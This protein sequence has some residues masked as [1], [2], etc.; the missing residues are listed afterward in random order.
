[1][2]VIKKD[3]WSEPFNRSKYELSIAKALLHAGEDVKSEVM[4][5]F[6]G[7]MTAAL[8]KEYESASVVS[9]FDIEVF[10][11]SLLS[12]EYRKYYNA[13]I[14]EIKVKKEEGVSFEEEIY[15]RA[16]R[17]FHRGEIRL[18]QDTPTQLFN[19]EDKKAVNAIKRATT[20]EMK[21][22]IRVTDA[23]RQIDSLIELIEVL[24]G[25]DYYFFV[26][27]NKASSID[28]METLGYERERIYF[29][30]SSTLLSLA[31]QN[32]TLYKL[33]TTHT[34]SVNVNARDY[35]K[36]IIGNHRVKVLFSDNIYDSFCASSERFL[37]NA[38][39]PYTGMIYNENSS[40]ER[41][42][43]N[44]MKMYDKELGVFQYSKFT[45]AVKT[46]V[47]ALNN[48][49]R[50]REFIMSERK[51]SISICGFNELMKVMNIEIGSEKSIAI[52]N[53]LSG[54]MAEAAYLASAKYAEN[55][56]RCAVYNDE[57]IKNIRNKSIFRTEVVDA[58]TNNG[59]Y[60]SIVIGSPAYG[61]LV[62]DTVW[63]DAR[64]QLAYMA[65]Y[66]EFADTPIMGT[67]QFADKIDRMY[68]NVMEAWR[69]GLGVISLKQHLEKEDSHV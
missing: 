14:K 52:L 26:E 31:E 66:N 47:F 24:E 69:M 33:F 38:I 9:T 3:G 67:V 28:T 12:E 51:I 39:N 19:L 58:V 7:G 16:K 13:S 18:L 65:A 42:A 61:E 34:R 2:Q 6:I 25:E 43:V 21:I 1:M 53:S 46:L 40:C 4:K 10:T 62:T 59:V 5:L 68:D 35:V 11:R 36:R 60:N 32:T 50:S 23:K 64:F 54:I 29:I 8:L 20:K 55:Y 57:V 48:T 27:T 17:A 56:G 41:G 22:L 45:S 30:L 37:V 44:V 15:L 63:K 49:I